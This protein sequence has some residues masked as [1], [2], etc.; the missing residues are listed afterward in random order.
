MERYGRRNNVEISGISN[1]ASDENLAG[2][3]TNICKEAGID[4][5][6]YDIEGSHRLPS[7]RVNTSNNKRMIVKFV[8]R[9]H[10]EAMLRLKSQ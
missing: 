4:L 1:D 5:K 8:N 9:K 3:L 2:K 7:G 6:P 10:S